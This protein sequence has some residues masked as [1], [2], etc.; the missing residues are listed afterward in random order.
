MTERDDESSFGDESIESWSGDEDDNE[1]GDLP[2]M[3][4]S[5]EIPK[6]LLDGGDGKND[7]EEAADGGRQMVRRQARG[8][9][10]RSRRSRR[11]QRRQ[12][13]RQQQQNKI[14]MHDSGDN[15]HG[16]VAEARHIGNELPSGPQPGGLN[17]K[18]KA[19]SKA[20]P[21]ESG[22]CDGSRIGKQGPGNST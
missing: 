17:C 7:S 19:G 13:Q 2:R 5:E 16:S 18:G 12:F 14:E 10:G 22:S 21:D 4:D 9:E 8:A 3:F 20:P 11:R 6:R 15:P 1:P